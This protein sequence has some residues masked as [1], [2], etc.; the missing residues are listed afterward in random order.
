MIKMIRLLLAVDAGI[1]FFCLLENNMVWLLNTQVAFVGSL[2]VTLG[3]FLGYRNLIKKQIEA[4]NQGDDSLLEKL[5]DRFEL[6]DDEDESEKET[7]IKDDV[8]E[9]KKEKISLLTLLR[10]SSSG[11]V[12]VFRIVG[13][14]VL[15]GSFFVLK[16]HQLFVA[17][18][19]FFGLS[20]VPVL[21]IVM[22]IRLK[23]NI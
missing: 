15:V 5:N 8:Q 6:Y 11:V 19:F 22:M 20:I 23:K 3:S 7:S 13:Y 10:M 21:A 17:I 12:S 4:G 18:P 1:A 16:N 9:E 14:G 2:S